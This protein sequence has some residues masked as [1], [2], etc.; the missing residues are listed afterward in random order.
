M[1]ASQFNV[2]TVYPK[3]GETLLFNTLNGAFCAF[4]ADTAARVQRL[5]GGPAVDPDDAELASFLTARGF[6]VA[7]DIDEFALVRERSRL[8]INDTNRLDVIVMPNMNCNLACVYCYES[9]HK[10]AMTEETEARLVRWLDRTVPRFKVVLLSW[11]GGEPLLSYAAV[12]RVQAHV[13]ELC[14]RHDVGFS[15]HMTTNGLLLSR[16]KATELAALDLLSYQITLDGSEELHN[17]L[18]P[19]KGGGSSFHRILSNI[20][21]LVDVSPTIRV[22]LRVNY[23]DTNIDTIPELLALIPSR[24]RPQL[25]VVFERIFGEQYAKFLDNMPLRRIGIALEQLYALA[26]RLGYS[27]TTNPLG[28]DKLTYCYADRRSMFL[29]NYNGDVFKCTVDKFE[30]KDRL[31]W[32]GDNGELA[33]ERDRLASWHGV[34]TFEEKCYSCTFAPMCMGGCRKLRSREGTV[35]DDCQLPFAGFDMRLQQRFASERGDVLETP[36]A[37]PAG[38]RRV[39]PLVSVT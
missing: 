34:A 10:S 14:V 32:L 7:D 33:W 15:S 19:L 21:A 24:V 8:G 9:H 23:N 38:R 26:K 22:T 3:T 27:V 4:P 17:S 25:D 30:S 11:F 29:V 18:R 20:Y 28:P 36:A 16:E 12:A 35:G 31:G 1:K 39:L 2:S 37:T 13:R 5:C 6:L